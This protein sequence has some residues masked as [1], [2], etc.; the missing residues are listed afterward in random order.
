MFCWM[1]MD[2][3]LPEF[4]AYQGAIALS[5]NL[6]LLYLDKHQTQVST[7]PSA[8]N[9]TSVRP[10]SCFEPYKLLMS[11]FFQK[12]VCLK[13]GLKFTLFDVTLVLPDNLSGLKKSYFQTCAEINTLSFN[14]PKQMLCKLFFL[15]FGKAAIGGG[16]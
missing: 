16:I 5:C 14:S 15:Q 11:L 9:R 13:S 8:S 2:M 4:D 10:L 12:E 6:E 3:C 1:L 7:C